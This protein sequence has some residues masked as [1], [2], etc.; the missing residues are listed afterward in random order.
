MQISTNE[1]ARRET[2]A[3]GFSQVNVY[4]DGAEQNGIMRERGRRSD[5]RAEIK[6]ASTSAETPRL[7]FI[8]EPA[9]G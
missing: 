3:S 5:I 8:Q 9:L 4:I 6:R 2:L 1:R 7:L